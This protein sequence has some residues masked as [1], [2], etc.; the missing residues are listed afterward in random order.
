M[1]LLLVDDQLIFAESLKTYLM[2]YAEDMNVIGICTNGKEACD[3]ISSSDIVPDIIL[4]DVRMPV[5]NGVEATEKIKSEYPDV[6]II[7]LSTYDED[8]FVRSASKILPSASV[9]FLRKTASFA[10]FSAEFS[11]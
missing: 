7:M 5:M 8:K 3:F 2:N 6:K 10:V 9:N 1:N 11:A 4:M